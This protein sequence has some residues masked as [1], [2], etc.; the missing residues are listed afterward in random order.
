MIPISA[1]IL[2]SSEMDCPLVLMMMM[3]RL[4]DVKLT[5]AIPQKLANSIIAL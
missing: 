5:C 1:V 3:G 4:D 2:G